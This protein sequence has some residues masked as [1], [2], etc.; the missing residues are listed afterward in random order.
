[1][2]ASS[3]ADLVADYLQVRRGLGFELITSA[4]L[5]ADFAA[6]VDRSGYQGPVTTQLAVQ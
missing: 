5:L 3:Y 4:A 1:V 6:H 2:T